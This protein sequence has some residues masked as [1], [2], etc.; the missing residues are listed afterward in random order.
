M[1]QQ[2][3][4]CPNQGSIT[5]ERDHFMGCLN[6][7]NFPSCLVW[8]GRIQPEDGIWLQIPTAPCTP[9]SAVPNLAGIRLVVTLCCCCCWQQE[10]MKQ[11]AAYSWILFFFFPGKW[12]LRAGKLHTESFRCANMCQGSHAGRAVC[13]HG[14]LL[15]GYKGSALGG[16]FLKRGYPRDEFGPGRSL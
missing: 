14:P 11:R 7:A 10:C 12:V 2:C 8:L 15:P 13:C 1:H 5:F 9:Q 16:I 4:T 6:T 3:L